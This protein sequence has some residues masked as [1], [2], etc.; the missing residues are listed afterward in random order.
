ME[1][2]HARLEVGRPYMLRMP[3]QRVQV[4]NSEEGGGPVMKGMEVGG[5]DPRGTTRQGFPSS[6][7]ET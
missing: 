4:K 7:V 6:S 1:L 5:G 2:C 3:R